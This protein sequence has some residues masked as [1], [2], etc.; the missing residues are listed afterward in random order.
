MCS[1]RNDT[2]IL[3][4]KM[5]KIWNLPIL[6]LLMN[7]NE[8]LIISRIKHDSQYARLK[9]TQHPNAVVYSIDVFCSMKTDSTLLLN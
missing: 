4:V 8:M 6:M 5:F 3:I 9:I 7:M 2:Y 1:D